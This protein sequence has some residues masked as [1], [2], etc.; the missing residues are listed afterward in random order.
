MP[1]C[2]TK[3]A[4]SCAWCWPASSRSSTPKPRSL[5]SQLTEIGEEIRGQAEAVQQMEAEHSER[6]Q[7]GYAIEREAQDNRETAEHAGAGDSIAPPRAA[8][9]TK[10][11]APN[12]MRAPPERRPRSRNTEEQLLTA[13]AGTGSQPRN[14][15]IR[16]R[17][18]CQRAARIAAAAAGGFGSR[19]QR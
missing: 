5:E 6:T 12:W 15:A 8:A 10:S 9:P 3:C 16:Q 13:A 7:R 11:A 18:C 19:G 2:A 14:P 17:R 1:S 4:P